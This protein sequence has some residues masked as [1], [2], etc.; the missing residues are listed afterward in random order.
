MQ[1]PP[2]S[3]RGVPYGVFG[4]AE[5]ELRAPL[6]RCQF[7]E[8]S[9]GQTPS[10]GGFNACTPAAAAR[11]HLLCDDQSGRLNKAGMSCV[12]ITHEMSTLLVALRSWPDVDLESLRI[13]PEWNLAQN[14]GWI[15]DS[16]ELT[17]SGARHAGHEVGPAISM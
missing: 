12:K 7:P 2:G 8:C 5:G 11:R 13:M 10:R 14:W 15:T 3:G 16:G 17:M 4:T 6:T 1:K 9:Y